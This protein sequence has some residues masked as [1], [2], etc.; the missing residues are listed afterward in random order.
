M[1]TNAIYCGDCHRVLGNTSEFPDESVDLVYIDPP[2]FT[3]ESYEVIWGDGYEMRAFEDRW[4]GGVENY[5]AWMEP[6]LRECFRV[7]RPEGSIYLHCDSHASAHL[8]MLMDS[9]FGSSQFRSD[10]IWQRTNAHPNVGKN[11]GNIHDDILFYTKGRNYTWNTQYIPYSESHLDSSYRN[12]DPKT[13]RRYALR[14]LTASVYHASKG[15]YYVWKGHKPPAS[16]VWAHSQEEMEKLDKAGR[17]QYSKNGVPRLRIFA[18]EMPGVPLQDI[19]VD[20]PPIQSHSDERLGYP[21]QKPEALLERIVKASS[22]E[23][24]IVLDPMCGCGTAIAVAQRLGR[25]WVGIDVS[26]SACKLMVKRMRTRGVGMSQDDII[27]LPKTE[28]Q[29]RELQPFEFQNWVLQKLM[30]RVSVRKVGDMGIDGYLF[31][32][33]P[34]QVKQSEDVGRNVV[35]NFETAIRRAK[36]TRGMI[37]AFSF[38]KG[39]YEEVARAKNA[40]GLEITL[41]TTKELIEEE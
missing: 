35:D 7:L 41:K 32:G 15:Q 31:D 36:K 16:R 1:R 40:E 24:D 2:F 21:T 34:V 30:G 5:I 37:V 13:G 6:K 12:V 17:I 3:E 28:A 29:L 14:D 10:I 39:A 18:D 9:I 4:K 20:I 8:R 23:G 33:A 25:K 19:W 22:R 26:P 11:Y 27:G 38:G